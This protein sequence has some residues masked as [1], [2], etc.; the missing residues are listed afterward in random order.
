MSKYLKFFG[1]YYCIWKHFVK[2]DV[3]VKYYI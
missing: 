2:K 3:K 1:L